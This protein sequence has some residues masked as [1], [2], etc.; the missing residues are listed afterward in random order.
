[1]PLNQDKDFRKLLF[2]ALWGAPEAFF[3]F[4]KYLQA[5]HIVW[6]MGGNFAIWSSF[7]MVLKVRVL[8]SCGV[9]SCKDSFLSVC[10]II[11]GRSC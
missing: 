7:Y 4:K 3:S 10:S 6:D 5:F 1:M 9:F 11:S 2:K 8:I